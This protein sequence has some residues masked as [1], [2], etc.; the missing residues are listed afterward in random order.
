MAYET[1]LLD[2]RGPVA[3]IRFNRPEKL[4]AMNSRMKDEVIAALAELD[5]DEAVRV[6][7]FT[8]QGDKAFVAGADITEFRD[9]TALEQWDLYQRPLLY[10]AVDRFSKPVISMINGYCLGGGCELAL[11]CDIRIASDRAQIGQPEIN[12]GI[13]PGGGGASGFPAS[14]ASERRCSSSSP[15][16]GSPPRRRTA[17]DSSTRSSPTASS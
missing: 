10:D 16:T 9:R 4:N 8:G 1:I 6:V 12:I 13:I 5:A 7:V 3:F 2:R 15:G 17:S 14:F 11:A